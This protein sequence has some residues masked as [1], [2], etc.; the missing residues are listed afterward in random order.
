[1]H[2]LLA[3]NLHHDQDV[4]IARQ[5]A[6]QIAR[7]LD[8]DT[9][10]QTR[11]ATAVSE[12]VRNAFR[13]AGHGSVRFDLD[14]EARPQRLVIR[15]EDT[16]PGIAKLEDVLAGRYQS[17][18]G[19]G[20]GIVGARRLMDQ[21]TIE[22]D[23]SGTRVAMEKY[24]PARAPVATAK[25][26]EQVV[27][28]VRQRRPQGLV[29]EIQVQN[30]ELL[31]TLDELHRR[32][33]ELARLNRELEDT[34]RGVVALYAELD[35]KADHLRRADELKSRF[36]SNMTHEF[37]TP[38]NAIIGLCN[39]LIDDREQEGR[40]PEPELDYIRKA[41]DQLSDL[42]ND[43]LDLA[44]VEAGKTV[45]RPADFEVQSLFGALRGLLKPVLL[46]QSV[47]LVFDDVSDVPTLHTDES[48]VS[49]ILRNLLSNALKFTERGEVRVGAGIDATGSRITFT[50]KDTGIGIASEDQGRIFEE[51]AQLEHRL[52]RQVKGTGLGL[53]LSR[54]L[55]ELLGGGLTVTSQPGLGST[56]SLTIPIRY[57]A[58]DTFEP[59]VDWTP[60]PARSPLLVIDDAPDDQYFYDKIFRASPFQVY[61][62]YTLRQAEEALRICE[63]VA[64]IMDLVLGGQEAWDFLIRLKR[65]DR[66]RHLPVVIASVLTHQDKGFALGADAYLVKPLDRRV[67][68]DTITGLQARSRD[69]IRVLVIDDDQ[70]ARYL[71]RHCLPPPAFKVT[72]AAS[73]EE[74]LHRARSERPDV[75][76][77]DLVMPGMDGRDAL[78][79]L[80]RDP[81][82]VEIPVVISTGLELNTDETRAL[83]EQANGILPKRNLTRTSAP[84]AIRQAV[85]Q[86]PRVNTRTEDRT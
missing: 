44:K 55:A 31:R 13:Y 25:R 43:L 5:R 68:V 7:L 63:P 60:D 47:T 42:V 85:E 81:A 12:I 40:A 22:S 49:Q 20:M 32:Q 1:V 15:V 57:E 29:E 16:G 37:R 41:A 17:S 59:T 21:F 82:T 2:T 50:V 28:A 35:E 23:S 3:L 76:V 64:I 73:G 10:E 65:D 84:E 11:V 53:P 6:A 66:T 75:I 38:V 19:M 8:F 56:F 78:A 18:T 34:N 24:L 45:I 71:F 72:E 27:D 80:R 83:L 26:I 58:W 67:L 86:A 30:Q 4:V 52:Q 74:G 51:F 69:A 9:S 33:Q 14:T 36:L 61:P 39:L 46:N 48:K 54:R 79:A 70:M 62:A 77:L